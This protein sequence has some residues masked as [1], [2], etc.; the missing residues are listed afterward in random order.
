[1]TPVFEPW[2]DITSGAMKVVVIIFLYCHSLLPKGP[3]EGIFLIFFEV[4]FSPY[5]GSDTPVPWSICENK[6][7]WWTFMHKTSIWDSWNQYSST[8]VSKV[9]WFSQQNSLNSHD[10][11]D[12][13]WSGI[14]CC[15][16]PPLTESRKIK[17]AEMFN[18]VKGDRSKFET[19]SY[20][21]SVESVL[22][23]IFARGVLLP[24]NLYCTSL[25]LEAGRR[26][27]MATALIFV[28]ALPV[29]YTHLTLPTKRIV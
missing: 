18:K 26:L 11:R 17:G 9:A 14:S 27:N 5:Y 4:I 10:D 16:L 6:R 2:T 28:L 20:G 24:H 8:A 25:R 7:S 22:K 21:W 13:E 23:T 12:V 3:L 29:S 15:S 1:M 19:F